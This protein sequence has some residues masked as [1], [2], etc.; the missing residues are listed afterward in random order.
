METYFDL[1]PLE[2]IHLIIACIKYPQNFSKFLETITGPFC[3][4]EQKGHFTTGPFNLKNRDWQIIFSY[5][6]P[7]TFQRTMKLMALDETLRT[8][9]YTENWKE[10]F[11]NFVKMK[12]DDNQTD[13]RK[14]RDKITII[15]EAINLIYA[16]RV[17]QEFPQFY[18]KGIQLPGIFNK[19]NFYNSLESIN[20]LIS[21]EDIRYR[22]FIDYF[23]SGIL[24]EYITLE[25]VEAYVPLELILFM[26]QDFPKIINGTEGNEESIFREISD[27][28]NHG[29]AY[30]KELIR[31]IVLL[32]PP[33]LILLLKSVQNYR[34]NI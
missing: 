11:L 22:P 27:Y 9:R 16:H 17:Y 26:I 15:P 10:L 7:L 4:L 30:Y 8:P 25:D 3:S 6:Y 33:E 29:A 32:L 13:L 2:L 19:E 18:Q 28:V 31:M 12:L 21:Y 24:T 1:I 20:L 34:D 5:R 23:N 14:I